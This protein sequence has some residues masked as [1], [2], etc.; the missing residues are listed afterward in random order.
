MIEEIH[1]VSNLIDCQTL[2]NNKDLKC[3][4]ISYDRNNKKCKLYNSCKLF[5]NK[6]FNTYTKKSLL[7]TDGYNLLEALYRERILQ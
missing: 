6:N 2:C 5:Y 7:R 3:K 1:G 4:Y